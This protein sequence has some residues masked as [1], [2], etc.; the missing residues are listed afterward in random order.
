MAKTNCSGLSF[1]GESPT[2]IAILFDKTHKN[3]HGGAGR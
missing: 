3:D 2:E 1:S